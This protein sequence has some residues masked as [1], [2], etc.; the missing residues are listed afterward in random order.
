MGTELKPFGG[1]SSVSITQET[2]NEIN[3]FLTEI[4]QST[5]FVDST[6]ST[7]SFNDSNRTFSITPVGDSFSFYAFGTRFEKTSVETVQIND[8]N[9]LWYIYYNASGVLGASQSIWDLS[10]Q[11]PVAIILWNNGSGTT[12]TL[13]NTS[14][15]IT[16]FDYLYTI[17]AGVSST[18]SAS[19]LILLH[20]IVGSENVRLL[21]RL[22]Y[23]YIICD[24]AATAETVFTIYVNGT[25]KGTATIAA[26]QTSGTFTW[27]NT[28]NLVGGD[29]IKIVGPTV[30]DSTLSGLSITIKGERY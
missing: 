1:G 8:V 5:G 3:N 23:S 24:V 15:K 30:P 28:V 29:K 14:P 7:K 19:Q 27:N 4:N 16:K 17:A 25:S 13:P 18:L 22:P 12:E 11:V 6:E 10:T 2:V 26:G 9:G 21:K 20:A